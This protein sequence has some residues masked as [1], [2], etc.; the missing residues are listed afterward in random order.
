M[1]ATHDQVSMCV[2]SVHFYQ[3]GI[4]PGNPAYVKQILMKNKTHTTII[5]VSRKEFK[6]DS[7]YLVMGVKKDIRLG[8]KKFC[9]PKLVGRSVGQLVSYVSLSDYCCVSLS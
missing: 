4:Q 1:K 5:F 6:T 8:L 9:D 2:T 7:S 3:R